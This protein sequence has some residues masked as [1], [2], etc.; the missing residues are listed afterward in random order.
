[1]VAVLKPGLAASSLPRSLL[2]IT[3][4]H[5]EW[6]AQ[7][8]VCRRSMSLTILC[9]IPPNFLLALS[10]TLHSLKL[11]GFTSLT[12]G[13]FGSGSAIRVMGYKRKGRSGNRA[14]S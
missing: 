6:A 10:L 1:M 3:L 8:Y 9:F 2:G 5:L 12:Q 13:T 11:T 14:L 4:V 7:R